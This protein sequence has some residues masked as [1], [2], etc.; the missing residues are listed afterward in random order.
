MND[1]GVFD[2]TD[3]IYNVE[4]NGY[5]LKNLV[6]EGELVIT[7]GYCDNNGHYCTPPIVI[8]KGKSIL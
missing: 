3:L 1:S 7:A 4:E 2:K 8:F 6:A 5:V